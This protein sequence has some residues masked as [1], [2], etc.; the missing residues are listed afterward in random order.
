MLYHV[1]AYNNVESGAKSYYCT[2]TGNKSTFWANSRCELSLISSGNRAWL[3]GKS[4]I[5]FDAFPYVD[6]HLVR[7]FPS[8]VYHV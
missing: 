2:S 1:Y 7:G 4:P 6:A 8:H 5:C 3:A